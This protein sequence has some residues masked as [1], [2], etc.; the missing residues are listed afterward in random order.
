MNIFHNIKNQL[1]KQVNYYV[2]NV[3]SISKEIFPVLAEIE[4]EWTSSTW[5]NV[6]HNEQTVTRSA[7]TVATELGQNERQ[8]QK[9]NAKTG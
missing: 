8:F 7:H 1:T 3:W 2:C 5:T 9:Y 4:R 6:T